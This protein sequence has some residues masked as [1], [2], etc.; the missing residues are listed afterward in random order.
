M[1]KAVLAGVTGLR[2]PLIKKKVQKKKFGDRK[3]SVIA[4]AVALT[5]GTRNPTLASE[6]T[7]VMMARMRPVR[8]LR[9]ALHTSPRVPRGRLKASSNGG[10]ASK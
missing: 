5:T 2:K 3:S 4:E 9:T 10:R 1:H 8:A 7:K 6:A